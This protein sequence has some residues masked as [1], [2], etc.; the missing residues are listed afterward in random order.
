MQ[1]ENAFEINILLGEAVSLICQ[2]EEGTPFPR[3]SWLKDG[4]RLSGNSL[5]VTIDNRGQRLSISQ[6]QLANTG[7]YT[8]V[9]ENAAGSAQRFFG[10]LVMSKFYEN[11]C[12]RICKSR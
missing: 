3:I 5:D 2:V 10:L 8:C 4:R 9:A 12:D 7:R 6:A 11:N 1:Q